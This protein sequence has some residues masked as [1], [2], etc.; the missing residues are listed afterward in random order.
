[1]LKTK[2]FWWGVLERAGKTLA[3]TMLAYL[4]ADA[5]GLLHADWLGALDVGVGAAVLSVLTALATVTTVTATSPLPINIM[6]SY[7]PTAPVFPPP[8]APTI[9]P[10]AGPTP[11]S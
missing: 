5:V 3:Q 10:P 1:M 7:L 2:A 9:P 6:P 8:T 11:A 4:G